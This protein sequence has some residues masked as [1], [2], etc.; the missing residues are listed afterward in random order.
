MQEDERP[1]VDARQH[2]H[3]QVHPE[4]APGK[5][6]VVDG[7]VLRAEEQH[8]LIGQQLHHKQRNQPDNR[9]RRQ[10]PR[11][12]PFHAVMPSCAHVV[13]RHGNA[14][15]RQPNRTADDDLEH[16][17]DNAEN[18]HRNRGKF[19]LRENSVLRAANAQHRVRRRH[20]RDQ[21]DLRQEGRHA[22][23]GAFPQ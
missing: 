9:L 10:Q 7:L 8:H 2:N 18:R 11:Q 12:K 23:L 17:H 19:L 16:F 20:C 15:R 13:S 1:F 21:A 5:E 3:A 4:A 6:R 22:E 14:S